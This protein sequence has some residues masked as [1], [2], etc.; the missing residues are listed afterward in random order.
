MISKEN[1]SLLLKVVI[2][3]FIF[4]LIA[5]GF[6]YFNV[7]YTHD[8]MFSITQYNDVYLK[9]SSGRFMQVLNFM[10]RG[11]IV[12]PWLVG[13]LSLVWLSFSN[14][15]IIKLLNIKNKL[16]IFLICGLTSTNIALTLTNGSY[17]HE[18]DA[19]MLSL[20]FSVLSVYVFKNHQYGFL[21][22]PILLAVSLGFY[23]AYFQVSVLLMMLLII[24][25]IFS[26]KDTKKII[27]SGIKSVV[28]LL[29]G[30]VCYSILYQVVLF[31]S[32][33]SASMDYN[34]LVNVGKFT[35]FERIFELI[36]ETYQLSFNQ[37]LK[38]EIH[39][40]SLIKIVN[41]I[42]ISLGFIKMGVIIKVKKYLLTK[43]LL[44]ICIVVLLPFG[45][46]C[47][48]FISNSIYH[49]LMIFSLVFIYVLVLVLVDEDVDESNEVLNKWMKNIV[50][51]GV[52]LVIFNSVI[53]S[54]QLY[55]RK[56]MIYDI[57]MTTMNRVINQM[58]QVS[59]YELGETP[60]VIIGE[61]NYSS[62]SRPQNGFYEVWGLGTTNFGIT[63]S[64]KSYFDNVL[65]YPIV[66][67]S[68]NEEEIVYSYTMP[69]FPKE[70]YCQMINGTLIVKLS[71]LPN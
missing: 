7:T 19:F 3:T 37:F 53:Y 64:Y 29:A 66:L 61:L 26:N 12:V 47:V 51:V 8:A 17:I 33:V 30:L 62:L 63:Y 31:F 59:G 11:Y 46:N 65:G 2:F 58:E 55:L 54:N 4:G 21:I 18:A 28:V 22:S 32:G 48:N 1:Q 43:C 70:G 13:F 36:F 41:L 34:S 68:A 6:S 45:L 57:T 44:L 71:E 67:K 56:T 49:S 15:F 42:L 35:S 10:F 9:I 60:V 38:P 14:Y 52:L 40:A 23:Q 25:D 5:H 16:T 39:N 20:L 50:A 69:S 24:K 27:I